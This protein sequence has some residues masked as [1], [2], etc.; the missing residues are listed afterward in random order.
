MVF[1]KKD[2]RCKCPCDGGVC[3]FTG[4]GWTVAI[5]VCNIY[6]GDSEPHRIGSLETLPAKP[7][8]VVLGH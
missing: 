2:E 4:E 5:L 3:R 1:L 6:K 8:E 7:L